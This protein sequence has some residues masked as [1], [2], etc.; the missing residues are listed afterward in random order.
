MNDWGPYDYHRVF[1]LTYPL[2]LRVDYSLGVS[3]PTL[4]WGA[5][6]LGVQGKFRTRDEHSP[7]FEELDITTLER[8]HEWELGTY[9]IFGM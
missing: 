1:N 3:A 6:R 5:T 2:Q 9:L 7:G 8:D 4:E